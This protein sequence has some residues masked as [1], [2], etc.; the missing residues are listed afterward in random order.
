MSSTA[1]A[2][3][4]RIVRERKDGKAVEC[5]LAPGIARGSRGSLH[6][7]LLFESREDA[8]RMVEQRGGNGRVVP[9]VALEEDAGDVG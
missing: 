8:N 3:G 4:I 1:V 6:A 2:F 5:W 7:A 9:I